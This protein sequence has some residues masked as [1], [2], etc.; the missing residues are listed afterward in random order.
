MLAS[1][2]T[3]WRGVPSSRADRGLRPD[4]RVRGA[5]AAAVKRSPLVPKLV[6]LGVV[7]TTAGSLCAPLLALPPRHAGPVASLLSVTTAVGIGV[8][9]PVVRLVSEHFG[10]SAAFVDL[11]WCVRGR[12][13]RGCSA[14][15]GVWAP[16][17]RGVNL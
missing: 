1:Q 15:S 12:A 11:S 5:A 10:M 2:L 17:A 3:M 9:Y 7:S 4:A 14:C 8:G 16:D 13:H 6:L